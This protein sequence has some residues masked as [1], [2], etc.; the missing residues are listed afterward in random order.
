MYIVKTLSSK[1][2][3]AQFE[4]YTNLFYFDRSILFLQHVYANLN[5][6][7]IVHKDENNEEQNSK[8]KIESRYS[9]LQWLS[10]RQIYQ[11]VIYTN[12]RH[13]SVILV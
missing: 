8:N 10:E 5:M 3:K 7:R 6:M 13:F 1:V 11:F 4:R 2:R 9:P 12:K